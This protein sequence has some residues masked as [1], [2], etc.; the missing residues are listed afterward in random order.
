MSGF[1]ITKLFTKSGIIPL[2]ESS[3]VSGVENVVNPC[4]ARPRET[5]MPGA[6]NAVAARQESMLSVT[7]LAS[8]KCLVVPL[9]SG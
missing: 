4:R 8:E 6:G 2:P 7:E 5:C 1:S 3:I 9:M